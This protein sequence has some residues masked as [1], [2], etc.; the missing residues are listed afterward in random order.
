MTI[1]VLN[2]SP[3]TLQYVTPTPILYQDH[4]KSLYFSPTIAQGQVGWFGFMSD[5]LIGAYGAEG[6]FGLPVL[7]APYTWTVNIGYQC[8]VSGNNAQA[9]GFNM[10][11]ISSLEAFYQNSVATGDGGTSGTLSVPGPSGTTYTLTIG[12]S[13]QESNGFV[14]IL[15]AFS[16]APPAR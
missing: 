15:A 8:P 14:G 13:T 12:L 11:S 5:S 7:Q 10:N 4:G 1:G 3:Y 9:G 16:T 2:Q 6:A